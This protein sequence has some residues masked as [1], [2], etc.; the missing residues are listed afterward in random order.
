M[1]KIRLVGNREGRGRT[2]PVWAASIESPDTARGLAA[3]P[4]FVLRVEE[5]DAGA[6]EVDCLSVGAVAFHQ[7]PVGAGDQ[8]LRPEGVIEP[9][10]LR[11]RVDIRIGSRGERLGVRN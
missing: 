10:D 11:V 5:G 7:R 2:N 6:G 8:A 1:L 3:D 9:P 4:A